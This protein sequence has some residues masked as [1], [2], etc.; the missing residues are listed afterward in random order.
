MEM[1]E[2]MGASSAAQGGAPRKPEYGR[3]KRANGQGAKATAGRGGVNV[4]LAKDAA[5]IDAMIEMGRR[6]HAESRFRTL[7]LEID[8]MQEV[9]R[10][11]LKDGNPGLI[12]AERDGQM[13]GM[14]V[15]LL[16]EYYFAPVRTATVQLLYVLPEARGG[17]AAVKLLRALRRWSAENRAHDLHINVTTAIDTART[18]RFLRRMGFKQTGGNYVLEGE[19]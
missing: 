12:V 2:T 17:A 13:V 18:D 9:G 10:R 19:G 11:G 7:P 15:V 3:A 14:A 16:G 4:R 6:L 5:D 8:R 1:L